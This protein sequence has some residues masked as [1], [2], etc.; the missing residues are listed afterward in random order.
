MPSGFMPNGTVENH[1]RAGSFAGQCTVE[2]MNA[3]TVP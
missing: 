1:G 2:A 3:S